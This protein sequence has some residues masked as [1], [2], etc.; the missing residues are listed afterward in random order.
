M[1]RRWTGG[2]CAAAVGLG[3]KPR[4]IQDPADRDGRR[5]RGTL[6]G[7]DGLL[8]ILAG[9]RVV[10]VVCTVISCVAKVLHRVVVLP[11]VWVLATFTL[12]GQA[13]LP[14]RP[15]DSL[16]RHRNDAGAEPRRDVFDCA[17]RPEGQHAS[18]LHA[19]RCGEC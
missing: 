6:Q 15:S 13:P 11:E 14:H 2:G 8:V 12:E 17:A 4:V 16:A 18:S 7:Q 5:D 19:L 10:V 3:V 1:T 9:L